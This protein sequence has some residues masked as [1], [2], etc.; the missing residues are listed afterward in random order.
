VIN[1]LSDIAPPFIVKIMIMIINY[2]ALLY[3]TAN[4]HDIKANNHS[5]TFFQDIPYGLQARRE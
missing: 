1:E 3:Q 4:I 2:L 5:N